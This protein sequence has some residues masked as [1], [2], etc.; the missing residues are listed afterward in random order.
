[1]KHWTRS[2]WVRQF[3]GHISETTQSKENELGP[4]WDERYTEW[5]TDKGLNSSTLWPT[6]CDETTWNRDVFVD[7]SR[8]RLSSDR[9]LCLAPHPLRLPV[10]GLRHEEGV[11]VEEVFSRV[12]VQEG[13]GRRRSGIR[14][15][16]DHVT[17]VVGVLIRNEAHGLRTPC[18]TNELMPSSQTQNNQTAYIRGPNHYG[19][20][21]QT[22]WKVWLTLWRPWPFQ[23]CPGNDR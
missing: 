17:N 12:D 13:E 4:S 2:L 3:R 11:R 9:V 15:A 1:M 10:H 23:N 8:V 19:H 5:L 7:V 18:P 14:V 21:E 22:N 6:C 20:Q 16:D